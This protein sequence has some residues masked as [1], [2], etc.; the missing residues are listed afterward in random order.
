MAAR[1][2]SP[3]P[4]RETAPFGGRVLHPAGEGIV[5]GAGCAARDLAGLLAK[6]GIHRALLVT[7]PSVVRSGLADR[8]GGLLGEHLAGVYDGSREHT[9]EPAVHAGAALARRLDIDGVVSLGGSSVVDLAKGIALVLAEG[10]DLAKLRSNYRAGDPAASRRPRLDAPK[11]PHIAVPTTL[12]GAEFTGGAG[13]T[14][15]EA[16]AK[17]LYWDAKLTPRWVVLDPELTATTPAPLWAGTGMKALADTIE[18][19]CSRRA[20]PLSD[21]VAAASLAVLRSQLAPSLDPDGGPSSVEARARCQFAVGMVIPQLAA[22]GVGL[23]AGLRHQLGGGLGIPH[24]VA[25][26]IVLPHVVRWN[27]PACEAALAHAARAA[28][29]DGVEGLVAAVEALTAE[30]GLPARLRDVG[31]S[32]AQLPA[33]A[34]HVLGDGALATNPRRVNA[35]SDVMEILRAAW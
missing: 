23:V 16:G 31:V 15:L 28:G 21:A 1:H 30:V 24:G 27:R 22:V 35:A 10:D 8:V 33:V 5:Y 20:T 25:S 11:L 6:C 3:L 17:R 29:T 13:I 7:T 34:E 18:V 2:D 19:L 32:E 12:S 4:D 26:T 9:P 14:D